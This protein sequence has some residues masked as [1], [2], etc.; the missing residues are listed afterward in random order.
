MREGSIPSTLQSVI[1]GFS[2]ASLAFLDPWASLCRLR[3]DSN[4]HFFF[5]GRAGLSLIRKGPSWG[6]LCPCTV[7]VRWPV[8]A[9][10]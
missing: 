4:G 9:R 1:L 6:A 5:P 7:G 10:M 3:V 8:R 2:G